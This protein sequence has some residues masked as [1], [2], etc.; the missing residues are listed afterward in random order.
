[1]RILI[2]G[3]LLVGLFT[4]PAT[5]D[6]QDEISQGLKVGATVPQNMTLRDQKG[7]LRNFDSLKGSSGLILLFTRSLDW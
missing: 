4:A 5:A 7:D 1:M 3:L 2:L 6:I